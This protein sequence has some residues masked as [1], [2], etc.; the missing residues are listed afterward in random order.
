MIL[1]EKDNTTASTSESSTDVAS[2]NPAMSIH[3]GVKLE[4]ICKGADKFDTCIQIT[5]TKKFK[6]I[7]EFIHCDWSDQFQGSLQGCYFGLYL[8]PALIE[9]VPVIENGYKIYI[10]SEANSYGCLHKRWYEGKMDPIVTSKPA[11]INVEIYH[12]EEQQQIPGTCSK[13]SYF[14]TLTK[15]LEGNDLCK[16]NLTY[17]E[18]GQSEKVICDCNMLQNFCLPHS[19]PNSHI[20]VC[21]DPITHDDFDYYD[22]YCYKEALRSK[23][24]EIDD[25]NFKSCTIK[26]FRTKHW[27]VSN[28]DEDDHSL[29]LIYKFTALVTT[30]NSWTD[31]PSKTIVTQFYIRTWN[32]LIGTVGGT[33]GLFVGLSFLGVGTWLMESLTYLASC[34]KSRKSKIV[35]SRKMAV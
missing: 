16:Y 20:Q 17:S 14:E 24:K 8:E 31:K 26:E 33:L 2:N 28:R 19:L 22:W 23:Q 9:G 32:L 29:S 3:R 21:K 27:T 18:Y 12:V 30:S 7:Q 15:R 11:V 25:G 1:I 13:L 5:P 6:D 4:R 10:T 34:R 35:K